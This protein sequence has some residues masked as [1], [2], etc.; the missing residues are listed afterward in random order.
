MVCQTI[1]KDVSGLRVGV[2]AK[3]CRGP[4]DLVVGQRLHYIDTEM[5]GHNRE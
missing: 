5:L 4:P 1:V 3:V 2:V